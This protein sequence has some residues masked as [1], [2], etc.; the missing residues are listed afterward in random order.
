VQKMC[1]YVNLSC[2][3]SNCLINLDLSTEGFGSFLAVFT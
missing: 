2:E 3:G 1:F